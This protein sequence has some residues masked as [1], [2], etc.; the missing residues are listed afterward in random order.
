MHTAGVDLALSLLHV[1]NIYILFYLLLD[2]VVLSSV[3]LTPG[4][5]GHKCWT[6]LSGRGHH[7]DLCYHPHSWSPPLT[8]VNSAAFSTSCMHVIQVFSTQV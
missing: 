4:C 2:H 5:S 1:K 6:S 8:L 7:D 3:T